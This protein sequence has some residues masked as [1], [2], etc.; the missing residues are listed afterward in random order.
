MDDPVRLVYG[1]VTSSKTKLI[2]REE[3]RKVDISSK[4]FQQE[5][6][7]NLRRNRE[8]A[9]GS[10]GSDVINGFARFGYHYDLCEFP[11]KWII[12]EA[13]DTV[14]KDSEESYSFLW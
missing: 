5:F 1:R 9:N 7:E 8:E 6:L 12:G 11:E 10:I 4:P 14:V 3:C 13:K 2:I